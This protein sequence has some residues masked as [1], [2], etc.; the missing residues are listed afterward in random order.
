MGGIGNYWDVSMDL[1]DFVYDIYL[2]LLVLEY[3]MNTRYPLVI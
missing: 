3:V 2:D 1:V